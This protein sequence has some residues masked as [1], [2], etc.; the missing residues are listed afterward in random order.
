MKTAYLWQSANFSIQKKRP[1]LMAATLLC[2]IFLALEGT[3]FYLARKAVPSGLNPSVSNKVKNPEKENAILARKLTALSPKGNYIVIDTARNRL[4]M[5]KGETRLLEAVISSGSG[6]V[7]AEPSGKRTWVFDTP[8]GERT[9][10]S[11]I[12]NPDWVKPDWAFVEE[13]ESIP[14]NYRDRIER[15]MLGDYALSIGNGYLI[16]GTLYTR[17]LG[18]NVTHGCIRVGDKDLEFVYKNTPIGTKV[19][20]F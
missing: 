9:V 17:M 14:G 7:L 10:R 13:G 8:R 18:R 15:G 6:N 16:H 2:A 5:K 19:I 12:E 1:L 11:K 4:F 20:I 3:G